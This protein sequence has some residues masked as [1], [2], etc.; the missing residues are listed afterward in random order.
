MTYS[1]RPET[2]DH[3][4][5]VR[6]FLE[7]AIHD[8]HDRS[9]V[10]DASKLVEPELEAFDRMTPRLN[11]VEYGTEEYKAAVRELGPALKHHFENNDHHP[12]HYENGI[13]G[14]SLMALIEMLCDWRAASERTKQRFD[15]PDK[16]KSFSETSLAYN[17]KRFGYSD[18]LASILDNTAR[19]LGMYD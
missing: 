13:R 6:Y 11:E 10:H 5:R 19:E 4:Y 17:Q 16:V 14:M 7:R 9:D 15:D 1:S 18:E 8:L 12:E 2:W 3:I